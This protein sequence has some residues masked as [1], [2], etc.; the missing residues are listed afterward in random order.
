MNIRPLPLAHNGAFFLLLAF[1]LFPGS[2]SSHA[3]QGL[4]RQTGNAN[5]ANHE[6]TRDFTLFLMATDP[7]DELDFAVRSLGLPTRQREGKKGMFIAVVQAGKEADLKPPGELQADESDEGY[8]VVHG[9]AGQLCLAST[10]QHGLANGLYDARRA[11]LAAPPQIASPAQLLGEGDHSPHFAQR[12]FYHFLSP[13]GLERLSADVFTAEQWKVHLRRMRALNANQFYFDIWADQYYHA[14]YPATHAN[15][16]LYDRLRGACDYAHKLGLR[17]GVVLFP[18]QVP[19][20]VYLA[21]PKARAVEAVNYHGINMCPTRAWDRVIS[22]DTFLLRYFGSAVDDVIVEMQ[23]PG[24]CLCEQCCKHFPDLVIRFIQTYRKVPCGPSDRRI[25]LC[26]LHF[27]DWLE[28]P[29]FDSGVAF[30]IKDLRRR[31]FAAL[32]RGTTL[33]DIDNPTMDM[34]RSKYGLKNMYFFFDLDPE[35]G[36]ENHQVFPRVKLRRIE[37]QIQDSVERGHDGILDYRMM[38][39]AQYVADYAL[40]RKC[41]DP[42]VDLDIVMTELAA[43]W[44]I[45]ASKRPT[46]AQ[47]MRDLDDWWEKH[48]LESLNAADDALRDLAEDEDCSDYLTDLK[49]LI[50]VLRV[51]AHYCQEN[52]EEVARP[53]FFPQP[54]L[55][56]EVRDL[57]IN[58]RIFDAYTVH[59]HWELR[60]REVIGQRIRWWLQAL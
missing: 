50:V 38:P 1:L 52:R 6:T 26:T 27:R 34:G 15:K 36:I 37:S 16:A 41:W 43:E 32:P 40:F 14:D 13:W 24:S 11:L 9:A 49:D 22:F 21:H 28:E 60:S 3:Q 48:D 23:D 2:T 5:L 53:D 4:Q 33:S 25:D 56:D 45:P 59:Q 46:F 12:V 29:A 54:E 20:S 30:P 44:K 55:V 58:R 7:S 47:A 10:T 31:V 35:S 51:L 18:C 17:T 19:A 57:M 42:S 39:F 8:R